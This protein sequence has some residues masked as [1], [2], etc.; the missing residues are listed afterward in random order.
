ML[1]TDVD[2]T[3]VERARR[4][5]RYVQAELKNVPPARLQ[6]AFTQS[7]E[8]TYAARPEIRKLVDI[9]L[10]NIL[11]APPMQ[12]FDLILCRNVVI[13]FTDEAKTVLYNHLVNSLRPGGVL[14]VGGTEMVASAHQ[15]GLSSIGPSFYRKE[16]AAASAPRPFARPVAARPAVPGLPLPRIAAGAR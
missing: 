9:R 14:F 15:L 10:H 4:A 7:P 11:T 5:D 3:I 13:Y 12:G 8:G 2:V 1:A 16:E 6:K